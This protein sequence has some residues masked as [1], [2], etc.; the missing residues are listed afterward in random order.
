[1]DHFLQRA[2][3]L[4]RRNDALHAHD[5]DLVLE[6]H[7][8]VQTH[9]S[10]DTNPRLKERDEVMDRRVCVCIWKMGVPNN[11]FPKEDASRAELNRIRL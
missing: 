4:Q 6:V 3:V 10:D 2:C 9:L 11:C 8:P 5:A 7:L 1:M